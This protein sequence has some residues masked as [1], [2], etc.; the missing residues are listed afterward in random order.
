MPAALDTARH[1]RKFL[2]DGMSVE[3]VLT[4]VRHHRA[5][6]R[7][8]YPPRV[9]NNIYLDTP[10]LASY[11]AHVRGAADR[12]K[13]RLRWYGEPRLRADV[14]ALERKMKHGETGFKSTYPL[15]PLCVDAALPRAE[16]MRLFECAALP[17]ALQLVLGT[18]EPALLNRYVRRYYQTFDGRV[19]VTVDD[20]LRFAAS[21]AFNGCGP[22]FV[23]HPAVVVELKFGPDAVDGAAAIANAWPFRLAKCSKYVIG[24]E[25]LSLA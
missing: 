11:H 19:R 18:M 5:M 20:D 15:P 6:L 1:E 21:R 16:M 2:G 12:V 10:G 13:T 22:R 25:M 17:P 9:V 24:I 8:A 7:E 3:D 14:A 4:V 23:R